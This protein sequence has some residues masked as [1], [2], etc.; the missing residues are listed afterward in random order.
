MGAWTVGQ[1]AAIAIS[2]DHAGQP[3]SSGS[4]VATDYRGGG[5]AVGAVDVGW[6]QKLKRPGGARPFFYYRP[7][8]SGRA[9]GTCPT[10]LQHRAHGVAEIIDIGLIDPRHV[11][12]AGIYHVDAV[13]VF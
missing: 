2:S 7:A 5:S 6:N 8:T 9:G 4:A 12:P 10:R 13:L 1:H 3:P 11:D